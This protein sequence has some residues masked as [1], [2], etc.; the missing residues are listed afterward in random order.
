LGRGFARASYGAGFRS[1]AGQ[2][3][4]GD[5]GGIQEFGSVIE[6]DGSNED[7]VGDA[8]DE[9]ADAVLTGEDGDATAIGMAGEAGVLIEGG[10]GFFDGEGG[11]IGVAAALDGGGDDVFGGEH[12]WAFRVQDRWEKENARRFEG[13]RASVF[14]PE[15]RLADLEGKPAIR[16]RNLVLI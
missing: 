12:G 5:L 15:K 4:A 13:R 6:A 9:G 2:G 10:L 3:G 11:V 8:G 16:E 14:L 1:F 7:A